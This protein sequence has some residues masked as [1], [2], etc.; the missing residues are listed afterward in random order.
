MSDKNVVLIPNGD[1]VYAIPTDV[2]KK[3]AL[4]GEELDGAK[5]A[6]TNSGGDVE[7]QYYESHHYPVYHHGSW[8]GGHW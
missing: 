8:M 4:E 2:C 1:A 7:G 6:L 3:Y 5:K